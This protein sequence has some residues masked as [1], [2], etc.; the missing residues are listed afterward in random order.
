MEDN[1]DVRSEVK[2][3]L[4]DVR[5]RNFDIVIVNRNEYR[6]TLNS[7]NL[8]P[9]IA[10]EVIDNLNVENYYRG[11]FESD[12][13]GEGDIWEFGVNIDG[14]EIYIKIFILSKHKSILIKCISFHIA[15]YPIIYP[16]KG[17]N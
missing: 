2:K 11:P 6:E 3:C 5:N 16:L 9:G 1:S 14:N 8:T 10:K 15:E 7:L 13:G 12:D 17:C 4:A